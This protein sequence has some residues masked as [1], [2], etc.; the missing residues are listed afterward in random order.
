MLKGWWD[1]EGVI[2]LVGGR[3]GGRWLVGELGVW[4]LSGVWGSTW[5]WGGIEEKA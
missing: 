2:L 4:G 3:V 1:V 5:R